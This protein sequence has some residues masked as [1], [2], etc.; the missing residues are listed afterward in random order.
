MR[1]SLG[2]EGNGLVLSGLDAGHTADKR[3]NGPASRPVI[4]AHHHLWQL[5]RFPYRWLV[6]G[7][8]PRPFGDQS[9]LRHDYLRQDYEDDLAGTDL[10]ASVFVEANAGTDGTA[11]LE[12]LDAISGSSCLPAAAIG[13]LDLR[14]P[15]VAEMLGAFARTRRMRGI[16]MPLCWSPDP[17][18]RFAD[19][20]DIMLDR[21]FRAGLA[22]LTRRDL[23][24][25]VVVVPR[26]LVQLAAL[27]EANPEQI[28]VL[29]HLGTPWFET[30]DDRRAW[31]NGMKACAHATNVAV[32]ISGLWPIDRGWR[33]EL[34]GGPVR[35]VVELFGPDRCLWGSNLPIENL[36]CRVKD[37]IA[38]LE[39]V[40]G[41]LREP[42]KDM[43]FAGTAHRIYRIETERRGSGEG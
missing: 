31:E 16:R 37:Q 32:K 9:G 30:E 10:I 33:P 22:E 7:A 27:A 19:G 12:W 23:L 5:G 8:A 28:F 39:E 3:R 42:E 20:P 38:N 21:D 36:M 26:Q 34:I 6:E 24:F 43:I 25:E 18:W 13:Q 1:A 29:E 11:E 40:L 4:D 35:R 41:D 14:R 17:R 15:D 2:V